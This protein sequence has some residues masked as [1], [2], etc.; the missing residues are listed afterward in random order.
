M[1]KLPYPAPELMPNRKN[2]HHWATT[3][4]AKVKARQEAFLLCRNLK[5]MGGGLKITF[6]TPDN[7][8]RDLDNLLSAMKPALDGMAQ[9]MGVDDSC[10]RPLLIDRVKAERKDLARVEVEFTKG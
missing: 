5:Y 4:R 2:G 6:Y 8:K 7:R 10:F 9:A 3:Q 1:I